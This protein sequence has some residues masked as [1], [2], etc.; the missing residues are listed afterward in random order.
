MHRP[1]HSVA[2][3]FESISARNEDYWDFRGRRSRREHCH[4][5]MAYPAMMVPQMQAELIDLLLQV[6]PKIK[7]IYDPFVGSGTVLAE[8]LLRGKNFIGTDVN[9]LAILC[10]KSKADFFDQSKIEKIIQ[11]IEQNLQKENVSFDLCCFKGADKW[12]DEDALKALSKIR[13]FIN[14]QEL[15]WCRRFLW[16]AMVD[17]I[18]K[19]SNTRLSTYKL[20][21]RKDKSLYTAEGIFRDFIKKC[22]L[23]I[24]LK[25]KFWNEL[26]ENGYVKQDELSLKNELYIQDVRHLP[27]TVKADLVITSPPYG[28]NATTITY[29]QYSYLPLQFINLGDIGASFDDNL[30][31]SQS[32]IDSV[33]LG[34]KLGEWDLRRFWVEKQSPSLKRIT[35]LLIQ[36]AKRGERKLIMFAYDLFLS[37]QRIV[38]TLSHGGFMMFTLGNRSIS[39]VSIPLDKIV[40][41]FL[42][43][44]GLRKVHLLERNIPSKRMPG[45]MKNEYVLIM[46]KL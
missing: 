30:I 8:A 46:Q 5:L 21:I 31:C 37:L 26:S 22:T 27:E 3:K 13:H 35:T 38:K 44:L 9:P 6:N 17:I 41:E 24:K 36:K 10:C 7:T 43:R 29:G 18:R 25:V 1:D 23:N 15:V 39:S 16:I 28:D 45:S 32:A 33:S 4:A 19:Y 11:D 34:G 2:E 42:E 20:H 40:K 12:F 14:Q